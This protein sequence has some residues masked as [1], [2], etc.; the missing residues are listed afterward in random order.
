MS[1]AKQDRTYTRTASDLEIKLGLKNRFAEVMGVAADAQKAA[2]EAGEKF[3]NLDQE[4]IFNLLTNN[5]QAQGIYRGD[6]GEIYINASYI[7]TGSLLAD[8]IKSGILTSEDGKIQ[9]DLSGSS[10]PVFN[11]GIT[12]NGLV[13]KG[14][15]TGAG[16]VFRV[17][18]NEYTLNGKEV[19]ALT[20]FM[21]STDGDLIG[22][23]SETYNSSFVPEG[24]NFYLANSAQNRFLQFLTTGSAA[25]M[26]LKGA[27]ESVV[28]SLGVESDGKS[29]L[30]CNKINPGKKVLFSGTAAV[31]STFTVSN[32]ADYDLFGVRLGDDSNTFN[33]IVLAYKINGVIRGVGGWSG[34]STDYKELFFVSATYSDN[35][36]TLLDVTGHSIDASGG[37]SSATKLSV[38]QVIG[39][40]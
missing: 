17:E 8:L 26:N 4:T 9:I 7:K 28:G 20:I 36:W 27:N 16:E 39:I 33:H 22:A 38:K 32:T 5:G 14:G 34:T 21:Q 29:L 30:S 18:A 37:L 10:G 12:T 13:I 40:I 23:I 6:D 3:A 2:E 31:D 11:T 15:D 24:I 25:R 1:S 19:A 35:T